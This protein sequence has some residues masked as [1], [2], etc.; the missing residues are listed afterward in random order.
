MIKNKKRTNRKNKK[1]L[2]IIKQIENIRSKN[3]INWMNVLRLAF[4]NSPE[5]AAKIMSKIYIHDSRIGRLV[6]KLTK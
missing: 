4:K 5:K 2:K 3:N 6:N 1:Y